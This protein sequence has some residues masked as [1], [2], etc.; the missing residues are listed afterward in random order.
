MLRSKKSN[1]KK[2]EKLRTIFIKYLS[3]FFVMTI[4]FALLLMLSFS[5]LLSSGVIL[6]ANYSE[7]NLINI[8]KRLFQ[9]KKQLKI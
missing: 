9:V 2:V 5:V 3:L 6:P 1:N 7:N 4:S 8:K